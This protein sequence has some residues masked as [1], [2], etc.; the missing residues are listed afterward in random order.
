MGKSFK[1]LLASAAILALCAGSSDAADLEIQQIVETP[2]YAATISGGLVYTWTDITG[3]EEGEGEGD[4]SD[5]KEFLSTFGEAAA[6]WRF[7]DTLNLQSD[8]AFHSHRVESVDGCGG[9]G[10][11]AIDQWHSGGVAFWRDPM[12]GLFGIDGAWGGVDLGKAI[13]VWRV[14]GRGEWFFGEMATLG[15][16]V[17]YH[18]LSFG[19]KGGDLDGVNF[20]VF[21]NFY[22]T[23]DFAIKAKFDYATFESSQ[24]GKSLDI[25]AWSIGGEGEYMLRDIFGGGSSV[26]VGGRYA[27]FDSDYSGG[28]CPGNAETEDAQVF[29]GF[30]SY[31]VTG[32]SLANHHRTNTVDNTNTLLERVPFSA[33]F[34]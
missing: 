12:M 8:F 19:G 21:V 3:F 9:C 30:R 5:G 25:D 1:S 17:G 34:N 32:G 28:C 13:D 23:E 26:F 18:N 29:V 20:N 24:N 14:G 27:N 6:L 2:N 15:G 11:K 10:N 22:A 31:F 4:F 7:S 33:F 16:G